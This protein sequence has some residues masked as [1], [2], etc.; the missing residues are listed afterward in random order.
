MSV[1][2]KGLNSLI[3]KLD[4]LSSI[5]TKKVVEEVAS[6]LER[7][8]YNA[9]PEDSTNSKQAIAICD[10]REY[11]NG[12]YIDVGLSLTKQPFEKWKGAWFNNW[13]WNSGG[14][15]HSPHIGWFDKVVEAEE[16]KATEK[17]KDKLKAELKAFKA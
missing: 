5:E 8:I 12:T 7:A 9:C 13:G 14:E 16:T 17:L 11:P 10:V 2:I 15:F 1:D 3:K 4:K 6:S